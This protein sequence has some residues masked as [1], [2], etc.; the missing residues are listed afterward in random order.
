MLDQAL[1]RYN[2]KGL[3][4]P[5]SL[6]RCP[7]CRVR[8]S[9]PRGACDICLAALFMPEVR[10]D[11]LTLGVYE[12]RLETA[13][14]AFKFQHATRLANTFGLALAAAVKSQGWFVDEVC[15]VP[16]HVR[17]HWQRG[18]NQSAL[19]AKKVAAELSV[20]YA[21]LL[22]RTRTTRQQAR[23]QRAE[24][25]ENVEGA[26]RAK[27]LWGKRVLLIDDVITS[28]ATTTACREALEQAGAA[29]IKVA[30]VARAKL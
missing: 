9:S 5:F 3:V 29:E 13:V 16:L 6:L 23:L 28:G 30:A 27:N 25:F 11:I 21:P 20:P 10:S 18:Y 2:E 22:T 26:F 19:I 17:R 24:R 8:A 14:R 1:A 15:A 4:T 7:V 12:G